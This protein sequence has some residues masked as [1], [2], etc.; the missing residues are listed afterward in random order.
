MCADE[1]TA[2]F[3]AKRKKERLCNRNI[4]Y[5]VRKLSMKNSI[6]EL[7]RARND[8]WGRAI[9]ERLENVNDLVAV[10]AQYHN[11]CMKKLYQAPHIENEKKEVR[12]QMRSI[13]RCST[14]IL[15]LSRIPMSVSFP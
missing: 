1:I 3:I 5:N 12:T 15:I 14:F 4:V 9:V 13:L 7:A 10:D 2:E 11:S 6:T 8:D